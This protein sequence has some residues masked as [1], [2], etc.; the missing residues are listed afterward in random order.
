MTYRFGAYELDTQTG[1]LRKSGVRLR[2]GGQ[3]IEVLT[4]LVQ[5]AGELVTREELKEALWKEDTFTDFDHGV[6]TAVQR[7]RRTLDD[8]ATEP[9]FIET[10]PRRG[11]RFLAAVKK[12]DAGESVATDRRPH[13]LWVAAGAVGLMLI[14]FA[15]WKRTQ[16]PASTSP[17]QSVGAIPLTSYPGLEQ[18]AT[19]SADSSQVA[20]SWNGPDQSNVD[21]YAKVIGDGRSPHRLTKHPAVDTS[22]KWS[23]DGSAIGFLRIHDDGSGELMSVSPRGGPPRSIA[24]TLAPRDPYLGTGPYLDWAPDGRSIVVV[25]RGS[26]AEP[27]HLAR[28]VVETGEKQELTQPEGS[29]IGDTGPALSPDGARL[30]FARVGE[31]TYVTLNVAELDPAS[32]SVQEVRAIETGM[33]RNHAPDWLPDSK[34]VVFNGSEFFGFHSTSRIY[35]LDTESQLSTPFPFS[36]VQFPVVSRDG[37]R[38]AFTLGSPINHIYA[39]DLTATDVEPKPVLTSTL[40]EFYSQY[41]PD[42]SR[43]AF[44]SRRGGK[45]ELWIH[46]LGTGEEFAVADGSFDFSWS[47]DGRR[48]AIPRRFPDRSY[49]MLVNAE[50]GARVRE[51]PAGSPAGGSPFWSRHGHGIFFDTASGDEGSQIFLMREE[52]GEPEQITANG[53]ANPLESPDGRYVYFTPKRGYGIP[54]KRIPVAGGA[55]ETVVEA[56]FMGVAFAVGDETVYYATPPDAGGRVMLRSRDLETGQ[57]RP[58][59]PLQVASWIDMTCS[60]DGRTLLI[61]QSEN[62]ADIMLAELSQ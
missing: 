43:I 46:D 7:I 4:L 11:Y 26:T 40:G 56:I 13:G 5:R 34:T 12:A 61:T 36:R 62:S 25:D 51:L 39:L 14:G 28:V 49:I 1:E 41:S 37:S 53:G 32:G 16:S 47:P 33:P 18:Y 9:K 10:L 21:V 17:S 57:D 60:P 38:I 42:G 23:P 44:I 24:N 45:P 8:S 15:A 27:F 54:L 3:P 58:L 48:I 20:F 35:T 31:L 59:T 29:W 2:L 22:P 55:E 50:A 6:N 30:A 52:G 19:F